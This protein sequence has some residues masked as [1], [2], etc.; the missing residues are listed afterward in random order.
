MVECV[1]PSVLPAASQTEQD[2]RA[3]AEPPDP[4]GQPRLQSRHG[5]RQHVRNEHAALAG[6]LEELADKL[7]RPREL[8]ALASQMRELRRRLNE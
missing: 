2:T 5:Y 3:Q 6:S 1:L 4:P 8:E 7:A